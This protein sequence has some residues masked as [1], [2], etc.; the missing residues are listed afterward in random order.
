MKTIIMRQKQILLFL[1]LVGMGSADVISQT[2]SQY[3]DLSTDDSWIKAY[4]NNKIE[5]FYQKSGVNI[6]LRFINHSETTFNGL[7]KV[8]EIKEKRISGVFAPQFTVEKIAELEITHFKP[9]D[10]LDRE[11]PSNGADKISFELINN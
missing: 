2:N 1:L 8:N 11:I 6:K 5:V 7:V 3:A 10:T 9:G 4:D